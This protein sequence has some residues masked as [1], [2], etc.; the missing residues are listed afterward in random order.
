MN[1]ISLTG[2][3]TKD[4]EIKKFGEDKFVLFT[5]AENLYNGKGNDEHVN[6]IDVKL[7][8]ENTD[9]FAKT[10]VKGER[11][12]VIGELR[13]KKS[14]GNDGQNYTNVGINCRDIQLPPKKD[15]ATTSEE[16]ATDSGLDDEIPF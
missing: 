11:I 10:L 5:I 9:F 13:V 8:R 3:I 12:T 1:V 2:N 16:T 14:K 7:K 15:G 4:C 6:Y